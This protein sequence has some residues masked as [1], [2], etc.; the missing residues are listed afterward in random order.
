MK[1]NVDG[2]TIWISR[3]VWK[4]LKAL[5]EYYELPNYDALLRKLISDH[6]EMNM[7]LQA[8]ESGDKDALLGIYLMKMHHKSEAKHREE[9]KKAWNTK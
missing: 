4:C 7:V 2:S 3:S 1:S 9:W 5:K 6:P 8:I